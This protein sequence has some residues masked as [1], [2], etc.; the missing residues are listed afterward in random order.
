M[1]RPSGVPQHLRSAYGGGK[2]IPAGQI[3]VMRGEVES[4]QD[5]EWWNQDAVMAV[6]DHVC[7]KLVSRQCLLIQAD[8][9]QGE[10]RH[11]SHLWWLRQEAPHDQGLDET[12][13]RDCSRAQPILP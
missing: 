9:L 11:E 2:L 3:I 1:S 6:M 8:I 7:E 10:H 4:I 5:P 12:H 13:E